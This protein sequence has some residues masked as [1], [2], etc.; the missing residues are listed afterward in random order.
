MLLTVPQKRCRSGSGFSLSLYD[1]GDQGQY[2]IG[3][4]LIESGLLGGVCRAG[5][6]AASRSRAARDCAEAAIPFQMSVTRR[7]GD[8]PFAEEMCSQSFDAIKALS[9]A[10]VG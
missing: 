2:G 7:N 9:K 3:L 8:D 1:E 10:W 4:V 5:E 6:A